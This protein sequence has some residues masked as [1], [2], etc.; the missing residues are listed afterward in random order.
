MDIRQ[1][2][3]LQ[4][5]GNLSNITRAAEQLHVSQSTISLAIQRLEDELEIQLF[6]RSQKHLSLTTEGRA[7]WKKISSI[8]LQLQDAVAEAKQFRDLQKGNFKIGVPPMIGSFL[9][10]DILASFTAQYPQLQLTIIEEGS[11]TLR[12][13]L[14]Q[15]EL[16]LAIVNLYQTTPLLDTLFITREQFA[17]CLPP[18]HPL[19]TQ[20]AIELTQLQDE[21]FILFKEDA[22]NRIAIIQA[23]ESKGF[24]PHVL[25]SSSQINTHK[26]LVS[27]GMGISFL[28]DKIVA[29]SE[30]LVTRPLTEPIYLEFGLAWHKDKYLSRAAQ[31]FINFIIASKPTF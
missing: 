16:D 9:F 13:L 19:A 11:K 15:S 26:E 21:P 7:F 20:K 14:E 4:M 1:L 23:C 30:H 6:D 8:L 24:T 10:P 2:E 12:Q 22:Y 27:K 28:I 18:N 29:K 31:A 3:Y 25:L 17:V 5:V